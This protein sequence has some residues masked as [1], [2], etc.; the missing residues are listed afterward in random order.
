MIDIATYKQMHTAD[1]QEN[2]SNKDAL[3]EEIMASDDP[4]RIDG[5]LLCLPTT[6]PGFNMNKKEWSMTSE[7][8]S[9][10]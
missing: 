3:S 6:I 10:E 8:L 1:R 2:P 7:L 4:P 5:F 9:L